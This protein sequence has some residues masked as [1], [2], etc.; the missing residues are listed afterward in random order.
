MIQD[1]AQS[2]NLLGGNRDSF[3]DEINL[4]DAV[5]VD[6]T[7]NLYAILPTTKSPTTEKGD[8]CGIHRVLR[9]A[10]WGSAEVLTQL[11]AGDTRI[12]GFSDEFDDFS[13][14][15]VLSRIAHMVNVCVRIVDSLSD[16]LDDFIPLVRIGI[17]ETGV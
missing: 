4:W 3:G 12:T 8:Q 14:H 13:A 16:A 2:D 7:L 6:V 9:P 10:V 1:S 15:W 11:T 17:S 5:L